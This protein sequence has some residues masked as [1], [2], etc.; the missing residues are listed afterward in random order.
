MNWIPGN[1]V[2]SGAIIEFPPGSLV[3]QNYSVSAQTLSVG[4]RIDSNLILALTPWFDGRAPA[5]RLFDQVVRDP[6]LG[7]HA[8]GS[9]GPSLELD[10]DMPTIAYPSLVS[11]GTCALSLSA[12]GALIHAVRGDN[13][14]DRVV[15]LIEPQSWTCLPNSS[16]G[17]AC[18]FDTWRLRYSFGEERTA[19]FVVKMDA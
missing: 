14:W 6:L 7:I 19:T 5:G 13:Q 18:W 15:A 8:Y 9:V 10:L 12:T 1:L 4:L 16:L 2:K 3:F 11:V 17:D